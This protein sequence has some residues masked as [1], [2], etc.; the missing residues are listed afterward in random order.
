MTYGVLLVKARPDAKRM[1]ELHERLEH[2]EFE[3]MQPFGHALTE[4]LENAR[5]NPKTGEV[6]REEEDYCRPPLRQERNAVLDDYFDEIAVERVYEN[7]GWEQIDE[8][9]SLWIE[10]T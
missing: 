4:A 1:G 2:A 10:L 6:L 3:A 7:Q 5:F 8:H 9:A